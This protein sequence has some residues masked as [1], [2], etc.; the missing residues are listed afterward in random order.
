[1]RLA[2]NVPYLDCSTC[3]RPPP[4]CP[5][6]SLS[7][8]RLIIYLY[9]TSPEPESDTSKLLAQSKL[10]PSHNSVEGVGLGIPLC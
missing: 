2:G 3:L 5:E 8:V 4:A 6:L 9:P 7:L 10:D 1:M